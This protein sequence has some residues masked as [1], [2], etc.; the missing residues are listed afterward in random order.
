MTIYNFQSD[1]ARRFAMEQG[2]RTRESGDELQ[3]K[4]CPYCRSS[5]DQYTFAI[6]LKSGQFHCLRASCGVKGNM[7]TLHKDFGFSLGQEADRY[8]DGEK[9]YRDLGKAR[10]IEVKPAAIRYMQSRGISEAVTKRYG[11]TTQK[12]NENILVFPFM[13]IGGILRFVKYRKTDFD[14][15]KDNA[16]EWCERNC[17]PI[18]F[19]MNQ[20]NLQNKTLIMTEGQIDSLSV[21]E[22]GFENAVSVPTG[23]NGFTWVPHCWDF[24]QNFETLIVFGDFERGEITLLSDME[25]RFHGTVKHVLPEDYRDCK[26]ANELLQKYGPDAVKAAVNNAEPSPI[27]EVISLDRVKRENLSDMEHIRTSIE[28]LDKMLGGFYMGQLILL[29]GE[30]GDGKSTLASQFATAALA[31]AYSVFFYSGELLDWYFKAWFD[32]QCAGPKHI[33]ATRNSFGGESYS[34]DGEALDRIERWYKDRFYLYR[35]DSVLEDEHKT[36]LETMETAIKQYGCRVLFLDNLMTAMSDDLSRDQFRQQ[37]AFVKN[38]AM[39]AKQYNVLIFLVAHP[40]KGN[41][42]Q[43]SND[44]VAGSSNI[45]NLVDVT[46]RYTRPLDTE[47]PDN[48]A[49]VLQVLK[50]RLNGKTHRHNECIKLYF[51]EASRR[52]SERLNFNWPLGW[53]EA[54]APVQEH[55]IAEDDEA[56]PF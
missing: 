30:R 5:K 32:F 2:A 3:F 38:L 37:T 40:R 35:N 8:Y 21:T 47:D 46:L 14:K 20:C 9:K 12:A 25:Q 6:N 15:T 23:K 4:I 28:N 7:I 50:N 49:R 22:A 39:M 18:L 53:E 54:P 45:T 34:V 13:D 26:D 36:L 31:Q 11:I 24:L 48:P 52:I 55:E 44:D 29:T 1:D 56:L 43:F 19:G 10:K 42:Y 51:N 41:G 33:N 16:K 27:R 17:M